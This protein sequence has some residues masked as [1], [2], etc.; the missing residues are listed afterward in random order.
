MTRDNEV[1]FLKFLHKIEKRESK[2]GLFTTEAVMT[3][4]EIRAKFLTYTKIKDKR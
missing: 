4:T 2:N 1:D 3:I